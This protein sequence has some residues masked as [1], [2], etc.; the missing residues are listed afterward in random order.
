MNP[1]TLLLMLYRALPLVVVLALG[2]LVAY[3]L[4]ASWRSPDRAKRVVLRA[5]TGITGFLTV[6][7]CVATAY[8]WLENNLYVL[9][10]MGA[11]AVASALGLVITCLLHRRY[12]KDDHKSDANQK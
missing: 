9:E 8:A 1:L 7:F 12:V 3:L 4:I 11:L 10:F 5:F 2:A 6:F